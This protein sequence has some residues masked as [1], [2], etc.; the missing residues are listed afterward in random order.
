VLEEAGDLPSLPAEAGPEAE[1]EQR[2]ADAFGTEGT[3]R[4]RLYDGKKVLPEGI[5]RMAEK[6]F[7]GFRLPPPPP[8][9]I[10]LLTVYPSRI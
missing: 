1:S 2:E 7:Q 10:F 5:V 8:P 3:L 9:T 6:S 4:K